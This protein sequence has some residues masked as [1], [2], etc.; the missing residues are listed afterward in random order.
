[1]R[2]ATAAGVTVVAAAGNRGVAADGRLVYGSIASPGHDPSVITVGAVN[3]KGTAARSDRRHALQ[4][5]GPDA[6]A[7]GV[8]QRHHAARQPLQAGHGGPGNRILGVL[9][10][11]KFAP[12]TGW[13]ALART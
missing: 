7:A 4:R 13:N 10:S 9:G 5:Q 1:V 12:A 6:C 3:L 11:D 8:Q 2:G